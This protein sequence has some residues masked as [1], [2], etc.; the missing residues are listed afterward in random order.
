MALSS[1]LV[2]FSVVPQHCTCSACKTEDVSASA[3]EKDEIQV[4]YINFN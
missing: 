4:S 2:Q 1:R 3:T